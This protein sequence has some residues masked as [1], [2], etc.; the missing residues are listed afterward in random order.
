MNHN[1]N[2]DFVRREIYR[3]RTV[4]A[5]TGEFLRTLQKIARTDPAIRVEAFG[6]PRP[7]VGL[8]TPPIG[9]ARLVEAGHE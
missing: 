7:V 6:L 3:K 4:Y 1:D 5:W 9:V 2:F 8:A